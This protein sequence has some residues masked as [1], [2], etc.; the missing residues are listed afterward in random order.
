MTTEIQP[1]GSLACVTGVWQRIGRGIALATVLTLPGL[2]IAASATGNS[3]HRMTVSGKTNSVPQGYV[4]PL[5][6]NGSLSMLVDY[7]GG[8]SQHAYQR[9]T[10]GIWW[11]GR[12]YGP[13]NDQLIP[14]GH[15]EQ[16]LSVDGRK[17]GPHA[18]WTQTLDTK[19]AVMTCRNDYDNGLSVE[20]SVFT[21]LAHD[22]V[23]VRK[24]LVARN[25]GV[26][27]VRMTFKYQFTPPGN[28]NRAPRRVTSAGAWN[29]ASRSAEFRY[30]ADGHRPCDGIVSIFS[31]QPVTAAINKQAVALTSE[32]MLDAVKPVEVTTCLLF[33][34]SLDG[35]DYLERAVKLREWVKLEGY[36]GLLAEHRLG[37]AAYWGESYVRVPDERLEKA[38]CTA[39]YHLRVN[40]TKWS[41]PVGIFN[42]HWAGRFFGWDEMFCYQALISSNHRD[43]ARRC[44][45]F[46]FAGLQKALYRASHY[47][48]PGTYGA[49]F[50]WEA[51]EDGSEAAPP[52]FWMEHVFHMSNI[53]LSAWFQHLYT[54]DAAY[55]KNTGYPV[56]KE[57]ARFFLANMIY[58]TP[59][60]GMFIGKCTDLERLGPARQNPFMTSCGAIYTLEA[61]AQAAALLKADDVEAAAWKH[62][63]AKLRES[64]P[65][66]G[67]R[68]VPYA[69]C[70]EESVASLGG[71]FPYP[72]FDET[73][74]RQRNAVYHFVTNGRASGNMYPVGNSV[75]AWY[76]GWMA[77]ALAAL[78]DRTEPVKLLDEAA[79]GAG[80]FG[81]MF[82]I[83]EPKVAMHPWFSTASGNVV[84]ALNQMLVQCRGEQ[85]RIAPAVPEAWKEFSFKL[86]CHGN[87]AVE[88]AVKDG[89][90]TKLMLLPGDAN[91]THLRKLV[92]PSSLVGEGPLNSP[93]IKATTSKGSNLLVAIEFKGPTN[94]IG[95]TK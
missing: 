83:N 2:S 39:Q 8:Q 61:A 74:A 28:E 11:A 90:F 52:G 65:H 19:A 86:A 17:C 34:D 58:E 1:N 48:K 24:R 56:I 66:D 15:F 32:I 55:L 37:W 36:A 70:K 80:C 21:P 9:M 85:I 13:P 81:E 53:A 79:A 20:T 3:P 64:L 25:P 47:G 60:G 31:D 57:C 26:R 16:E 30:Q 14:F 93:S 89:R 63:A 51:L 62:A 33:A 49:R 45:E 75:C 88:V 18:A 29:E 6:S 91:V 35:K 76:A 5:V 7:Q 4:P 41:F 59:D 95:D 27:S 69:G 94:L 67:D 82:E 73:D 22:L 71:L 12:R 46:R 50:P 68:Y 72:L 92:L 78:G 84:Y 42:T 87:L 40:A 54:D 38:Y 77:A 43:I 23:V 44:P 10:S